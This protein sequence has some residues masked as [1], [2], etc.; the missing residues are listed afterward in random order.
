M[1]RD[2][3][4]ACALLVYSS[5]LF[6]MSDAIVGQDKTITRES[7]PSKPLIGDK[8]GKS[9]A[10]LVG[11]QDYSNLPDLRFCNED[12]RELESTLKNSC[13]FDEIITL[14]DDTNDSKTHPTL[15]IINP[16][17]RN[18]LKIANNGDYD[19]VLIY[20][21]GHGFR[22]Q[23]GNLYFAPLDCDRENLEFTAV[24]QTRVRE[25]L[26]ACT[27]IPVKLL[28]LDCCHAGGFRG[29][30]IGGNGNDFSAVFANA[31]GLMT[32]ASCKDQEVS[33]EWPEKRRGL[34][35]YWLCEGLRGAADLDKDRQVDSSELHKF[36][37]DK[38]LVTSTK[39]GK[40]QNVVFKQSDDWQG[41]ALLSTV[42]HVVGRVSPGRD[43]RPVQMVELRN[44]SRQ[45]GNSLH[46][47][48]PSL[49]E[50]IVLDAGGSRAV[51]V[52]TP[53]QMSYYTGDAGIGSDGWE[54]I[55][56]AKLSV[57]EFDVAT[58]SGQTRWEH[59]AYNRPIIRDSLG[60]KLVPIPEGTFFMG[61]RE[62]P[63]TI[64]RVFDE[65]SSSFTD[66]HPRHEVQ[67]TK[68]FYLSAHEISVGQFR[69]F[70]NAN[71]YV[72]DAERDG[73]G[74]GGVNPN[75]KET[76]ETR[77]SLT[78]KNPGG[79]TVDESMPV[80][81]ISWN[82]A[83]AFC[84]WLSETENATY[85]LPTEAEWEYACRAGTTT[86]YWTG[87]DPET[88]ITGANVPDRSYLDDYR[89]GNREALGY[90]TL[91][92]R[93][94]YA[95]PAPVGSFRPNRFGL[96]DMHGN[97]WE[98]CQDD[99]SATMYRKGRAIDPIGNF[100]TDLR[101]IRGGCYM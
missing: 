76:F 43:I 66:E 5:F 4:I 72:T 7:K 58:V 70:V 63:A 16:T 77:S 24:S 71:R 73:R 46:V 96:F 83:Q 33:L 69:E 65:L 97:V 8:G 50:T 44:L 86:R 3:R 93:D 61:S 49:G 64:A 81:M 95:K 1:Q 51:T 67:I 68:P 80:A 21:S 15:G 99:Y 54:A 47:H 25:L 12:V 98:W 53:V 45:V 60:L 34:F 29:A 88:L 42:R 11:V 19:R 13:Q 31:K 101:V 79:Y 36:V 39:M 59:R 17:L 90:A 9:M 56:G 26:E 40:P 85:R 48:I 37:A 92:G 52:E 91:S 84:R 18:W 41:V 78:W 14:T 75:A 57:V 94:G 100:S 55:F 32:M 38:V 23:K 89:R 35:T 82:D 6:A 27:R 62:S 74:G 10:I 87:D 30:G 2:I 22:D 20:F 28:I